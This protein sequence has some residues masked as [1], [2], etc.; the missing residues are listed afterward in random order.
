VFGWRWNLGVETGHNSK[1]GRSCVRPHS[2][3]SEVPRSERLGKGSSYRFEQD[4]KQIGR[5][6]GAASATW[7]Q[8]VVAA[9]V[10]PPLPLP[11]L[12]NFSL[13]P[14]HPPPSFHGSSSAPYVPSMELP[15]TLDRRGNGERRRQWERRREGNDGHSPGPPKASL[16][17]SL[18][19]PLDSL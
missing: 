1:A 13:F 11:F 10:R 16:A 18:L 9:L 6:L 14:S 4:R 8:P 3:V 2:K 19:F 12:R 7:N 5:E 17:V 15:E